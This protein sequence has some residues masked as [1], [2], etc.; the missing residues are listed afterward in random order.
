MTPSRWS[1]S[2]PAFAQSDDHIVTSIKAGAASRT[3]AIGMYVGGKTRLQ[4]QRDLSDV[5]FFEVNTHPLATTD[6]I[7]R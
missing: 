1:L 6:L 2:G 3:I 4:L 7:V 5:L